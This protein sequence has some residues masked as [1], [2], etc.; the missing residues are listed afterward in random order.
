[1]SFPRLCRVLALVA[2]CTLLAACA[3]PRQ[4]SGAGPQAGAA[5]RTAERL[6]RAGDHAAAA[7]IYLQLAGRSD[8]PL[9]QTYDL[10]AADSL[11]R[12][13]DVEAARNILRDL[14]VPLQ[15]PTLQAEHQVL[16]GRLAI[17]EDRP[18]EALDI[19]NRLQTQG[20]PPNTR[21]AAEDLR[22]RAYARQGLLV[23]SLEARMAL[24]PLLGDP[25]SQWENQKALWQGLISLPQAEL[26]RWRERETRPQA[27]GWLELASLTRQGV[28]AGPQGTEAIAAWRL[29]YPDH[30]AAVQALLGLPA[31]APPPTQVGLPGQLALLL[32]LAGPLAG[33]A[34]AVRDGFLAAY[35]AQPQAERP[36]LRIYDSAGD[37]ARVQDIYRRAVGDGAQ[38]IVGPLTKEAVQGLAQAPSLPVP[39]LALNFVDAPSPPANLYQFGLSP[40]DEARDVAE[41]AWQDGR[42]VALAVAPDTEWGSRVL[43][44]FVSRWQQLGGT[45]GG[46]QRF[47]EDPE[48]VQTAIQRLLKAGTGAGA[49]PGPADEGPGGDFVFMAAFPRQ[50]AQ[51]PRLL[52]FQLAGALPVY[53]TSHSYS[54]ALDSDARRDLEGVILCDMPWMSRADNPA[55]ELRSTL[56]AAAP[57]AGGAL[58]RLYALGVDA[59]ALIPELSR[60]R[61][62]PSASYRGVTGTLTLDANRHVRRQLV[63]ARIGGWGHLAGGA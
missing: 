17:A 16:L 49:S 34:G 2:L 63:C 37:A 1:M 8:T 60:L 39:T 23:R 4:P 31:A 50:A 52:K 24:Q 6:E 33:P 22:A 53:A 15:P 3:A 56:E 28:L 7:Q 35:Y 43:G 13:G 11:L 25:E 32:P 46:S 44:A 48:S 47:H 45:L 42:R 18:Q 27:R 5:L 21:A 10:R 61:A 58:T 29:R 36:T 40:E 51:I 54:E 26:D 62:S 59:Y 30:P 55:P 41:R 19:A 38:L 57:K 9:R 14:V 20:L 12:A